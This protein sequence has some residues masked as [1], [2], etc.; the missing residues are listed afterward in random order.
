V[1]VSVVA[2]VPPSTG[3]RASLATTGLS[4][5]V[6]AEDGLFQTIVVRRTPESV[7]LT[8]PP[9]ATALFEL[10]QQ[11]DKLLPFEGTPR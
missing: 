2:L 11:S 9:D 4:R 1:R 6:T 3:I 8:A 7:V 5:I 10:E